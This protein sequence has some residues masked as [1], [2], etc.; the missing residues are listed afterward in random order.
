MPL[1]LIVLAVWAVTFLALNV[2]L[3]ARVWRMRDL[4]TWRRRL[5]AV[6]LCAALVAG[7]TRATGVTAI[8]AAVAFPLNVATLVVALGE[9]RRHRRAAETGIPSVRTQ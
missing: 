3:S 8:A 7:L 1:T 2:I 5:P 4:P 9:I 6:L